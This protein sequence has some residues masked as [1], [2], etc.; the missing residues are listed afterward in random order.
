MSKEMSPMDRTMASIS[1]KEPDRVPTFL[2]LTMHGAKLLDM[3]LRE[4]FTHSEHIIR[5]QLK[6][7]ELFGHDC[8]YALG[9]GAVDAEAI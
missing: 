3:P 4:Y 6:M 9:Y 7:R 2:L 1:H 8:L 5:A